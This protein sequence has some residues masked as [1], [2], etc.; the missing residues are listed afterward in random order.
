M[1]L[2]H[3]PTKRSLVPLGWA[4]VEVEL[5]G[6]VGTLAPVRLAVYEKEKLSVVKLV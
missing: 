1:P 4:M 2:V 3:T 6:V 5:V